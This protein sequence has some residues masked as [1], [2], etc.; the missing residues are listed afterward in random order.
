MLGLGYPSHHHPLYT[1][2]GWRVPF[3]GATRLVGELGFDVK[4]FKYDVVLPVRE[5]YFNEIKIN[6]ILILNDF[7]SRFCFVKE[8]SF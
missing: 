5:Y 8:M 2:V 1:Q 7:R 4:A 6:D 3:F